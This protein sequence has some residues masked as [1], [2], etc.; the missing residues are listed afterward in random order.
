ML[1]KEERAAPFVCFFCVLLFVWWR[2]S[3]Q[4]IV[5]QRPVDNN[6]KA[7]FA[8]ILDKLLTDRWRWPKQTPI[9]FW[10]STVVGTSFARGSQC[11]GN[12]GCSCVMRGPCLNKSWLSSRTFHASSLWVHVVVSSNNLC[13]VIHHSVRPFVKPR[14][15]RWWDS[16]PVLVK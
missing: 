9:L 8:W 2:Q 11:W 1:V 14:D 16:S 12:H 3:Q 13:Y 15:E 4:S 6:N 10:S 7:K 5:Y